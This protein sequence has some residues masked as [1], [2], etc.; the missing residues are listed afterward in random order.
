M[1]HKSRKSSDF[2]ELGELL[3]EAMQERSGKVGRQEKAEEASLELLTQLKWHCLPFAELSARQFHEIA[4]N[5]E[6]IFIEEQKAPFM[7]LDAWDLDALHLWAEL[8]AAST[9]LSAAELPAAELSAAELSAAELPAA[10]TELPAASPE[11]PSASPAQPAPGGEL[12]AYARIMPPGMRF[13]ESSFGRLLVKPAFRK[14]GLGRLAIQRSLEECQKLGSSGVRIAAQL[15]LVPF[16]ESLGFIAQG[17]SFEEIGI[18]HRWMIFGS[19][20]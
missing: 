4:L 18:K 2:Q 10:S 12:I 19:K 20:P 9:E 14:M 5:R 7:D 3:K 15:H 1:G 16:Y 17:E 6:A 13:P 11:Q 8:P